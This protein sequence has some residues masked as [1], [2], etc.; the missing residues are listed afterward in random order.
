MSEDWIECHALGDGSEFIVYGQ[1]ADG[2]KFRM[3]VT[4]IEAEHILA[5]INRQQHRME[6]LLW[7]VTERQGLPA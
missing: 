4:G 5:E 3:F 7:G 1:R 6:K 2:T